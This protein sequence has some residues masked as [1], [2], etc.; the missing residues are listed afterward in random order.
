M[1]QNIIQAFKLSIAFTAPILTKLTVYPRLYTE[2]DCNGLP[3]I[4]E[5]RVRSQASLCGICDA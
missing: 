4:A 1:G 3:L 2:I 5:T